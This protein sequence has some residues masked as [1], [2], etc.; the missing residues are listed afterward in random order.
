[1]RSKNVP[2]PISQ[3]V[4]HTVRV[5]LDQTSLKSIITKSWC[6][7][8]VQYNN[9]LTVFA[10]LFGESQRIITANFGC[11]GNRS[12]WSILFTIP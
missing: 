12:L 1:M 3:A 5:Y 6:C 11:D 2:F 8:N 4:N 9:A 10:S 7:Y